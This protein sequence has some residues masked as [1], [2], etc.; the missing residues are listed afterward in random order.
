MKQNVTTEMLKEQC[1]KHKENKRRNKPRDR[2]RR[3]ERNRERI[4]FLAL[5]RQMLKNKKHGRKRKQKR[6]GDQRQ[7]HATGFWRLQKLKN[8]R[9]SLI[10]RKQ[11][12]KQRKQ[13]KYYTKRNLQNRR[14]SRKQKK[15]TTVDRN[16]LHEIWHRTRIHKSEINPKWM[17]GSFQYL[18]CFKNKR[19]YR[20]DQRKHYGRA[21]G[22]KQ[23]GLTKPSM[24]QEKKPRKRN[25]RDE[26]IEKIRITGYIQEIMMMMLMIT[27]NSSLNHINV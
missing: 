2:R 23:K 27:W 13:S 19:A 11:K 12:N 15:Q 25:G 8:W 22:K 26:K 21:E 4:E 24:G 17:T 18:S 6:T 20:S 3:K 7:K 14:K 5:L 10:R 16:Q 1:I 9:K